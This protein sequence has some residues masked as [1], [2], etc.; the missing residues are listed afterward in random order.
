MD[1]SLKQ[2]LISILLLGAAGVNFYSLKTLT[3]EKVEFLNFLIIFLIS[4]LFFTV[5]LAFLI[6]TLEGRWK[7][8]IYFLL[9][10]L[11]FLLLCPSTP[12]YNLTY[13]IVGI[14]LF[15][16]SLFITGERIRKEEDILLR[17]SFLRIFQSGIRNFFTG[18]AVLIAIL[19]FLSPKVIGGRLTLPRSLFDA[20]W[21]GM[22]KILSSQM[23]GFS[24][25]MTVDEYILFQTFGIQEEIE[26]Q[27]QYEKEQ[28]F[29]LPEEK[30]NIEL[31]K[32]LEKQL[33]ERMEREREKVTDEMLQQ[34]R[35]QLKKQLG[36]EREIKGDEKMKDIFYELITE[37][38]SKYTQ[39]YPQM[40]S[41]GLI[42]A[43][44]LIAKMILMLFSYFC[45][46]FGWLMFKIFIATNFFRIEKI[47]EDKE[48]IVI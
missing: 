41:W 14:L 38:I 20:L 37:K 32:E 6:F 9:S 27:I 8:L 35:E 39:R 19:I 44:F 4:L 45:L 3:F 2:V 29:P 46:A 18:F 21:P 43:F 25:E 33:Q 23:P 36:I 16:L 34:G 28:V 7:I 30:M 47:K 10:C 40:G 1:R 24:G 13:L 17:F 31:E 5:F 48:V 11:L 26:D 12:S 22:E 42:L 15:L